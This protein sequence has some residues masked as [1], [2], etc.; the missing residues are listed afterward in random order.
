MSQGFI[1]VL[2]LDDE[3]ELA[4]IY[5][6][7]VL[8]VAGEKTQIDIA[9]D[10]ESGLLKISETSYDF[11][12][13]DLC[14]P[15]ISGLEFLGAIRE[16]GIV[17]PALL[18][19]GFLDEKTKAETEALGNIRTIDKPIAFD[20]LEKAIEA[21]MLLSQDPGALQPAAGVGEDGE[22]NWLHVG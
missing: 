7:L 9:H 6:N 1:K 4:M 16:K 11:I 10:G 3:E 14:M 19:S 5:E 15:R 2:I 22:I 21:T 12:L 13:T 17:T 20:Q 18:I 8:N